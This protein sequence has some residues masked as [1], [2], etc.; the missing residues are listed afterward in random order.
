MK[1]LKSF[2]LLMFLFSVATAGGIIYSG[3]NTVWY[4]EKTEQQFVIGKSCDGTLCILTIVIV[5]NGISNSLVELYDEKYGHYYINRKA[6]VQ[7][8][9]LSRNEAEISFNDGTFNTIY[10]IR[11]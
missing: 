2:L 4:S 7:I 9:F 3:Y 1:T 11:K 10:R 5:D 6:G 8:V